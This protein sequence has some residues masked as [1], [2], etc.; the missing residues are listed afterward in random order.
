MNDVQF[1]T[2]ILTYLPTSVRFRTS[3]N[4]Q[5]YH[6]VSD[7]G[8]T[9]YLPQ[10]RTSF[11]DVPLFN[12]EGNNKLQGLIEGVPQN[13]KFKAR[14]KYFDH[15]TYPL[16][17][18]SVFRQGAIHKYHQLTWRRFGYQKWWFEVN[19]LAY[20]GMIMGGKGQK[21]LKLGGHY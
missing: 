9:T 17:I 3:I 11:M 6:M 16:C 19:F 2:Y 20:C 10:N 8:N 21:T 4:F 12:S 15:H 18:C 13:S 1:F 14:P 7:F 5:F